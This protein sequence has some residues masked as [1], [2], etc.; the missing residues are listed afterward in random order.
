M[1]S[2]LF[3][4]SCKAKIEEIKSVPNPRYGYRNSS[5]LL[6]LLSTLTIPW[7]GF[8]H[9]GCGKS[10]GPRSQGGISNEYVT[11]RARA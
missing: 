4:L 9:M 1:V 10:F 5:I 6:S 11:Q 3:Q 7:A 2:E 8:F